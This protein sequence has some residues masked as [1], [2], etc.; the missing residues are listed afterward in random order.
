MTSYSLTGEPNGS[1]AGLAG[2]S[3][4]EVGKISWS[5]LVLHKLEF[6]LGKL[7]NEASTIPYLLLSR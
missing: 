6:Q 4:T 3:Y 1:V 2:D 5:S 7:T